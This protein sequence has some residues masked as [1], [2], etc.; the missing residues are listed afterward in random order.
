MIKT[1]VAKNKGFK[2]Q[3]ASA[4]EWVDYI[5]QNS[6]RFKNLYQFPYQWQAAIEP[7]GLGYTRVHKSLVTPFQKDMFAQ[8]KAAF[9]YKNKKRLKLNSGYRSPAYQLFLTSFL[10]GNLE[11]VFENAAPPFYSRHQKEEPDLSISFV[12]KEKD[13]ELESDLLSQIGEICAPF[14]FSQSFPGVDSLKYEFSTTAQEAYYQEIW[15]SPGLPPE[16]TEEVKTALTQAKFFPSKQ[17][18]KVIFAMAWKESS[19]RWDPR[20]IKLKKKAL[21]EKFS[22]S[23]KKL[24]SGMTG[25]VANYFLDK[26]FFLRKDKLKNELWRITEPKNFHLTEWDVYLWTKEAH[27]LL[28]DLAEEYST[29]AKFGRILFDYQPLLNRFANEPQSFGLWQVNINYLIEKIEGDSYWINKYPEIFRWGQVNREELIKALSGKESAKLDH[30][31]TLS[32]VFEAHLAPRYYSHTLGT[33]WD[34]LFFAT[35]NL[36]GSL[37]SYR[38]SLQIVLRKKMNQEIVAD[39]D[40]A[41]YHPY[42]RKVDLGRS[43]QTLTLLKTYMRRKSFRPSKQKTLV[44]ELVS[45]TSKEQLLGSKLYRM[46]MK[47]QIGRRDMPEVKSRII[48]QSPYSYGNKVLTLA[49]VY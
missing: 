1:K 14:G 15:A 2:N 18:L 20:L 24:D 26:N 27:Q 16:L 9:Y 12:K 39:G 8:C 6:N 25:K 21:R 29:L 17:G 13:E 5:E 19:W 37:S 45:A 36:T 35:E 31:Q 47:G 4:L 30:T 48:G 41:N 49:G 34:L 43:S 28:K 10:Q 33:E 22:E 3:L 38:T 11:E 40:L 7:Q 46:I 42:S 44:S 23:L 32:L